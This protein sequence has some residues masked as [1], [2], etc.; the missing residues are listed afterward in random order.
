MSEDETG[1]RDRLQALREDHS[2]VEDLGW[3]DAAIAVLLLLGLWLVVGVFQGPSAPGT[4][5]TPTAV[6]GSQAPEATF[7]TVQGETKQL[8]DYSGKVVL[9]VFTTWC[10]SCQQGA[11][12][13]QRNNDRLRNVTVIAVKSA[14]NAGYAGPSVPSFVD[15]YAPEL[16]NASNWVW[17]TLSHGSTRIW[18]PQNRPDVYYIIEPNGE[19]TGKGGAPAVTLEKIMRFASGTEG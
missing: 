1:L 5:G 2:P 7:T 17:G 15:Q 10:P 9:W 13:L 4:E 8:S 11:A 6:V 3:T 16:R 19:I 14:G 12:A 18:N